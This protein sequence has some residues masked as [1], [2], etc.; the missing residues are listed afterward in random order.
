MTPEVMKTLIEIANE[1]QRVMAAKAAITR[2]PLKAILHTNPDLTLQ[3]LQ[4]KRRAELLQRTQ[5]RRL[6]ADG[7]LHKP[8]HG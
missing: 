1:Q 5:A 6:H 7:V 4:A 8:E 3:E 2:C